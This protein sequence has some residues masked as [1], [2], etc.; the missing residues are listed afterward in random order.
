LRTDLLIIAIVL[1]AIGIIL[2][3]VPF[4]YPLG[5]IGNIFIIIGFIVL[6]VW[7]VLVIIGAIGTK[8]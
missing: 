2:L 1:I 4:G 6:V 8:T 7:V 3:Y 5:T